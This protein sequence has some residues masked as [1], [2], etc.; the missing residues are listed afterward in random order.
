MLVLQ[1]VVLF[2][3]GVVSTAMTDIGVG[4]SLG[5]GAGLAALCVLAAGMLGRPLGYPL[6]WF[7]QA[8]S[9]GL[10]FVV[11][12]MFLL[13]VVFA[14]LWAG[15]YLFGGRMSQEVAQRQVLEER[16]RAEHEAG[17]GSGNHP[18]RSADRDAGSETRPS[19]PEVT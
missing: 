17:A 14:A 16:W 7:V 13:G 11:T 1:A 6:G 12:P 18:G 19:G 9:I 8:L 5:M 15:A 2:L 4:A 3:F 10:G